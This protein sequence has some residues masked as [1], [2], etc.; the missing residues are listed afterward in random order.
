MSSQNVN[1][2]NLN[3]YKSFSKS[4]LNFIF[5]QNLTFYFQVKVLDHSKMWITNTKNVLLRGGG[6]SE[7][8][9]R[10]LGGFFVGG[11][12][13]NSFLT[14]SNLFT[15]FISLAGVQTLDLPSKK[16]QRW[17][18]SYAASVILTNLLINLTK[19]IFGL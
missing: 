5:P 14:A 4:S 9:G 6:E 8:R 1:F 2:W 7:A 3:F 13:K 17:L 10:F 18:L 16:Q 15:K 19:T 12:S 11:F